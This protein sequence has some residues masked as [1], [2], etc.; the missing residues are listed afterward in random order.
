MKLKSVLSAKDNSGKIKELKLYDGIS[1]KDRIFQDG[2]SSND[3]APGFKNTPTEASE[4]NPATREYTATYDANKQYAD[5][6]RWNRGTKAV[7]LSNNE[8]RTL[9]VVAQGKLNKKFPAQVPAT[10]QVSN[11]KTLSPEDKQKILEAVK[12]ANPKDANRIK[13]GDEGY[14]I[15]NDG[16]VTIT[17][18]DGTQN[19]VKP[20]VSD[21]DALNLPQ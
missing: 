4:T 9:T 3:S 5:G 18:K 7:D 8:A 11:T 15:S 10:V 14:R 6:N 19:T 20:P 21:S 17:Y 12:A 2:Y 13:D 1:D 16:T